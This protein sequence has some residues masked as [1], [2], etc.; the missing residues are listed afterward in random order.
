ML[1]GDDLSLA[2]GGAG[3]E[4]HRDHVVDAYHIAERSAGDLKSDYGISGLSPEAPTV[5][6]LQGRGTRRRTRCMSTGHPDAPSFPISGETA[7]RPCP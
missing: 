7:G 6:E 4:V 3:V 2:P 1:R 5:A